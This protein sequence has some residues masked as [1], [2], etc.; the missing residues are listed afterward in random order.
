[1]SVFNAPCLLRYIVQ[2][3]LKHIKITRSVF[4]IVAEGVVT[5][6]EL[7]FGRETAKLSREWRGDA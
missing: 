3:C 7:S 4:F 1:M 6:R 5:E 2:Y